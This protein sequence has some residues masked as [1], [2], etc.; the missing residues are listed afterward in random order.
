MN[1]I[2]ITR[3]YRIYH[4]L[5]LFLESVKA[6]YTEYSDFVNICWICGDY[7]KAKEI[8]RRFYTFSCMEYRDNSEE[9]GL[10]ALYLA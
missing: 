5:H 8:G 1:G 7:E 9:A 6:H 4:F 2:I 3:F 10:A